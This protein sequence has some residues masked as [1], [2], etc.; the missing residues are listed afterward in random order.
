[1]RLLV[2]A[3]YVILGFIL[4]RLIRVALR[5]VQ[6]SRED[7]SGRVHTPPAEPGVHS[8][9]IPLGEIQDAD[10][11]DLAPPKKDESKE[12]QNSGS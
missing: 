5:M 10:F 8:K 1:M 6:G 2:M 9:E 12:S 11:E 4:W 3:F 7:R